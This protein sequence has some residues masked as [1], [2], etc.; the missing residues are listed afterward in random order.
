MKALSV[1]LFVFVAVFVATACADKDI[2]PPDATTITRAVFNPSWRTLSVQ[3]SFVEDALDYRIYYDTD[4]SGPPYEGDDVP[5]YS[6]PITFTVIYKCEYILTSLDP[7]KTYYIAITA[8]D[9]AGNESEYS[10]EVTRAAETCDDFDNDGDGVY[11]ENACGATGSFTCSGEYDTRCPYGLITGD[12]N[13]DGRPDLI[14]S[15]QY[16]MNGRIIY[17]EGNGSTCTIDCA[18]AEPVE[19]YTG[20]YA[21]ELVTN[22]FNGDGALDIAAAG[23]DGYISILNGNINSGR[24]DGT[25]SEA[26]TYPVGKRLEDVASADFNSDGINDLAAV[27]FKHEAVYVLFGNGSDGV[28]DGTFSEAVRYPTAATPMAI[29]PEDFNSD[30]IQDL[31]VAHYDG[32]TISIFFGNGSNGQADGTFSDPSDVPAG[33]NPWEITTGDFNADGIVDLAV[34]NWKGYYIYLDMMHRNPVDLPSNAFED[35]TVT[36]LLG[37]RVDGKGDGTFTVAEILDV[38]PHPNCI[39][40]GDFNTDGI[41][42]LAVGGTYFYSIFVFFG[43]GDGTF[44]FSDY[45]PFGG[46]PAGIAVADFNSDN[47]LD[48]AVPF[49]TPPPLVWD[50]FTLTMSHDGIELFSG[51]PKPGYILE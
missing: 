43:N 1:F 35:D 24:S 26:V 13:S 23:T 9:D 47:A 45:Y 6:S 16:H 39:G 19:Y 30:G 11:D 27:D 42:D 22:D 38:P 44:E 15:T 10:V 28:G 25:F 3:W 37:N 14:V 33:E 36:I 32:S 2:T 34:A 41:Q 49:G 50:P 17:F 18:F 40:V 51:V 21:H 29:T 5:G 46:A 8:L 12:F 7:A 48:I 4:E 20:N 31:A